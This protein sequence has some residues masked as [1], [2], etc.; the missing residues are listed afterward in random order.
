MGGAGPGPQEKN[1]EAALMRNGARKWL[2]RA[3]RDVACDS[4]SRFARDVV[5]GCVQPTDRRGRWNHRRCGGSRHGGA[6]LGRWWRPDGCHHKGDRPVASPGRGRLSASPSEIEKV[7]ASEIGK[8]LAAGTAAAAA[9]RAEIGQVLEGID[10]GGAMLREAIDSGNEQLRSDLIA[11]VSVLG[12]DFAEFGFLVSDVAA[13]AARIQRDL[14]E[15]RANTRVIIE[16][17]I[18]QSAEIRRVRED[19]A[20]IERRTRPRTRAD[21]GGPD[22]ESAL[23]RLPLPGAAAVQRS[24]RRD[25]LRQRAAD[26]GPGGQ[27][28]RADE[29]RRPDRRHRRLRGGEVIVAARGLAAC[30]GPGVAGSGI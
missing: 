24:R 23:G 17:N 29:P 19:I 18:G 11:A 20:V 25:L 22:P 12:S 8:V 2:L 14:D 27:G 3:G 21:E 10:L 30:A 28:R 6:V 26:H 4:R 1:A 15:Q 9:L 16:Q 7:L 5:R 13:A